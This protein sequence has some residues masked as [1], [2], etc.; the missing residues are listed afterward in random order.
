[1][2]WQLDQTSLPRRGEIENG[3]AV[4]TWSRG[5]VCILAVV[6]ALGHGPHAAHAARVA[7]EE[8]RAVDPEAGLS[9]ILQRLHERLRGTRGA[10]AF[11]AKLALERIEGCSIGN[12]EAR[13]AS[14]NLPVLLTPGVLG[15]RFR[16]PRIF[17]GHARPG[18]RLVVFTDGI[19]SR[20]TTGTWREGP[21]H[22]LC[23]SI[24]EQYRR[25]HDDAT[26]VVADLEA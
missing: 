2:S 16:A 21:R 5:G 23:R 15:L 18:E 11:V 6:D 13:S 4:L 9:T 8:L 10:A 14:G 22:E 20:F 19:S 12:V 24:M 26:V 25:P 7:I 1:V 17:C 3:D